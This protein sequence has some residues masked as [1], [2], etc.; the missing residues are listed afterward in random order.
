MLKNKFPV[1]DNYYAKNLKPRLEK[2]IFE[3]TRKVE[4]NKNWTSKIA[5]NK[6][7][8]DNIYRLEAKA[9]RRTESETI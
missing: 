5:V 7:Y 1:F 2:F 4:A 3:P 9:H 8:I 6:Q